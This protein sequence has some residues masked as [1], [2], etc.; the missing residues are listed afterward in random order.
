MPYP[1]CAMGTRIVFRSL[2]FHIDSEFA[3]VGEHS[4]VREYENLLN[5]KGKKPLHGYE[6]SHLYKSI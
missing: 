2:T 6:K 1:A 5:G 4:T 3:A